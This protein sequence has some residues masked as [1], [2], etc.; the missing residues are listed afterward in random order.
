[1]KSAFSFVL[2]AT[3]ALSSLLASNAFA[4]PP[5]A[6]QLGYE[7]RELYPGDHV[8]VTAGTKHQA[9][10]DNRLAKS[11]IKRGGGAYGPDTCIKGYVWREAYPKDHV[12]VLPAI[13]H[14]TAEDNAAAKSR[15]YRHPGDTGNRPRAQNRQAAM[16]PPPPPRGRPVR[17]IG[18]P[19][20]S[21][22][23][24]VVTQLPDPWWQTPQE[25]NIVGTQVRNIGGY[26]TL[27]C[28]YQAYGR[29]V[30]V[31]RKMPQN[32]HHCDAIRGGFRCQ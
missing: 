6:C 2:F 12:C 26:P 7:W 14:A 18:C 30:G 16:T 13:R 23:T 29:T 22:R 24:E 1:M 8:C 4:R 27:T 32:L 9:L 15:L 31:M 20:H 5:D 17:L 19:L 21:V 11:R 3:L 28:F 10:R 25:G